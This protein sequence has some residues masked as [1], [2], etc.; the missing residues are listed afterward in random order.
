MK[1]KYIFVIT[2][3]ILVIIS[4][5]VAIKITTDFNK[6]NE[7]KNE[8]QEVIKYFEKGIYNNEEINKILNR[9]LI[10]KG[11]YSKVEKAL[12]EYLLDLQI[13]LSNLEFLISEDSFS[14][15][16]STSNLK[17]DRPTFVKSKNNLNNTKSQIN[18]IYNELNNQLNDDIT[19]K[20]YIDKY[21]V[22]KYYKDLYISLIE[23]EIS[24]NFKNSIEENKEQALNKL[25]IYDEIF[26]FLIANNRSWKINQDIIVFDN[27]LLYEEYIKM[28]DKLKEVNKIDDTK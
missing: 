20:T 8:V 26:N 14:N 6:E 1:K 2:I 25:T 16:L 17:E 13:N 10:I 19:I 5:I 4:L 11:K 24:K 7:I 23:N 18:E 3:I 22:K 28:T 12:K 21:E 15:Y 9:Q 27:N